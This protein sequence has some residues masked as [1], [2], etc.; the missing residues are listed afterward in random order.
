LRGSGEQCDADFF[1]PHADRPDPR[2][3]RCPSPEPPQPC[4]PKKRCKKK[5]KPCDSGD[6]AEANDASSADKAA[7]ASK[8]KTPVARG[9]GG[10]GGAASLIPLVFTLALLGLVSGAH[11]QAPPRNSAERLYDELCDNTNAG[12]LLGCGAARG[13]VCSDWPAHFR[14]YDADNAEV[15]SV[16]V[17]G[18]RGTLTRAA[19]R[20]LRHCESLR[21][22]GGAAPGLPLEL[23]GWSDAAGSEPLFA[24]FTELAQLEL[25]SV[26]LGGGGEIPAS[27]ADACQLRKLALVNV[28]GLGGTLDSGSSAVCRLPQLRELTVRR[29]HIG[30]ELRCA[31]YKLGWRQ[32]ERLDAR[33]NRLVAPLPDLSFAESLTAL[34][35][36]N[37]ALDGPFPP[38]D[39]LPASLEQL[40]LAENSLSGTLPVGW[41]SAT[42]QLSLFFVDGNNLTGSVPIF[43]W[44]AMRAFG[45]SN[46]AFEGLLPAGM[47]ASPGYDVLRV[48]NNKLDAPFPPFSDYHLCGECAF[49]CNRLCGS[50]AVYLESAA[51]EELVRSQCTFSIEPEL[52]CPGGCGD[53][54]CVGCDGVPNSGA[55]LD[56][57][58]V[59][60]GTGVACLD[61]AGMPFG[62]SVRDKCGVCDGDNSACVDCAGTPNGS[63]VEDACGVCGGDNSA[64]VDCEGVPNGP[65]TYDACGVCNGRNVSCSDCHWVPY[66]TAVRDEFGVCGGDGSAPPNGTL[67]ELGD[68][69]AHDLRK[70]DSG[71]ALLQLLFS[72]LA[73]MLALSCCAFA[74]LAACGRYRKEIRYAHKQQTPDKNN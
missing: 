28:A 42:P 57:C 61:C 33:G 36:D 47:V 43:N 37:N 4:K 30:G 27:L 51:F 1:D 10:G 66:G 63:A 59:C 69:L 68:E 53:R 14:C 29:T 25:N 19:W 64:C 3:P 15:R 74:A 32:L 24:G 52:L 18:L 45:I 13:N 56:A 8:P 49:E 62:S 72:L 67:P 38:L 35:A 20:D 71:A 44:P 21:I 31:G 16:D 2:V 50:D 5:P 12:A 55:V 73:L 23:A 39:I 11:A 34:L 9:P 17:A 54:S 65:A 22:V 48:N 46:N 6:D 41:D 58:G 7:T 40:C 60:N 70:V 26:S